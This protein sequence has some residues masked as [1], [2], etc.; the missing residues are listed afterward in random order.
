MKVSSNI[1]ELNYEISHYSGKEVETYL[2]CDNCGLEFAIYGVFATCPDCGRINSLSVF[3][4]SLEVSSKRLKLVELIEDEDL[5]EAILKD[6]LCSIISAFD[7][8]GK[9]LKKKYPGVFPEKPKNLF[10][11][12]EVLFGHI[13]NKLCFPVAEIISYSDRTELIKMFQVRHIIQHNLGVIDEEFIKRVPEKS[14]MLNKK[15]PLRK[16]E[17][18]NLINMLSEFSTRLLYIAEKHK[19][20]S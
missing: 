3:Q 5:K 14:H 19:N 16:L 11:N 17:I 1:D 20:D 2:V 10:Q 15:Y 8:F 7:G 4:K 12:L 13:E 9:S 6:T 18:E